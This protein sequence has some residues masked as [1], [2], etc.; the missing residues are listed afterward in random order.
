MYI[1]CLS[2]EGSLP[3][4][5]ECDENLQ[6]KL[7]WQPSGVCVLASPAFRPNEKFT[8]KEKNLSISVNILTKMSSKSVLQ[9][10]TGIF[11]RRVRLRASG[12]QQG[13]EKHCY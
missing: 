7:P 10:T 5:Q 13:G 11:E 9:T 1:S 8:A 4:D 3:S 2:G 6:A 12:R